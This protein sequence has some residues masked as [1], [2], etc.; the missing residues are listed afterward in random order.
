MLLV[1]GKELRTSVRSVRFAVVLLI[2]VP[3]FLCA[4]ILGAN[5]VAFLE[6][7]YHDTVRQQAES[8]GAIETF[9]P[10]LF[11]RVAAYR[12]PNPLAVIGAG[13]TTLTGDTFFQYNCQNPPSLQTELI[14][15]PLQRLHGEWNLLTIVGVVIGFLALLVSYDAFSG[16]KRDGT[17]RQLCSA[18]VRRTAIV[19]G[20]VLGLTLTLAV[21]L[22]LAA[23]L[24]GLAIFFITPAHS[25]RVLPELVALCG[26]AVLYA[27]VFTSLGVAVSALSHRPFRTL[28]S[29]LAIWV[30][31]VFAVPQLVTYIAASSHP[32]LSDEETAERY[33]AVSNEF[34]RFVMGLGEI[35]PD[36]ID[37]R[38]AWFEGTKNYQRQLR[39]I[40]S[41]ANNRLLRQEGTA[42]AWCWAS[43]TFA[44]TLSM[45]TLFGTNPAAEVRTEEEIWDSLARYT[46]YL[47]SSLVADMEEASRAGRRELRTY[48]GGVPW[49]EMPKPTFHKPDAAARWAGASVGALILL[50]WLGALL[51]CAM[52]LVR[53]YD[54]R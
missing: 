1:A 32:A 39:L 17:I 25:N 44:T 13:V 3:L 5:K 4:T 45:T 9:Y 30:L 18:P 19:L 20:K 2:V 6:Q 50:G 8:F 54:P 53:R 51:A 7:S 21:P 29:L 22:L 14:H 42:W 52:L 31:L 40:Y 43:P 11:I 49:G 23:V 38:N 34:Y 36:P 27:A 16:E 12:P 10:L 37:R 35:H 41:D 26:M 28:I 33:S 47:Q 24:S 46:G 15:N 48:P